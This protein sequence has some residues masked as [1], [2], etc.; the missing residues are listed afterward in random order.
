MAKIYSKALQQSLEVDRIIGHIR[1]S[2]PGPTL[3]FIGGIHGNEPA[4]VFA[5]K[6]VLDEL[7]AKNIPIKGNIY[8]LGGNLWALEK[9]KRYD[10]QD[11]NRL[12]TS[13]NMMHIGNGDPNIINEDVAQQVALYQII[14][15]IMMTHQGPFY[16]MD[17]HTTSSKTVP[18]LTVNDS[19]L[20][21]KFTMQ[22]PV[23]MILGIEEYLNGPLLSYINELGYIAFGFEAGQHDDPESFKRHIAFTYLTLIFTGCASKNDVDYPYYF[24]ILSKNTLN[25]RNIYEIFWRYEIQN[26]EAFAMKPG[27]INFQKIKKGETLATSNGNTIISH[28]N[29]KIFMPLY[30]KQGDDGF[31]VIKRTPKFFL[32]LSAALRMIRFDRILAILPG[33]QWKSDTKD[34]LLVDLRIARF[35]TRQFFH[36]LGYRSK[37]IDRTHLRMKNR[38]T[39]SR[40]TDYQFARWVKK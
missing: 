4:G 24:K 28:K 5:L 9:G 22:Y 16:F 17:L 36:L 38:E 10:E 1:G 11:L 33:V 3:V 6:R 37:T 2:Q 30:Q 18:F 39:A 31:F 13:E 35:F 29:G 8:A 27:F 40:A 15:K 32:K 21:R 12:W 26:G 14:Q 34:T 20:N 23:P 7:Q 25:Y 19:L